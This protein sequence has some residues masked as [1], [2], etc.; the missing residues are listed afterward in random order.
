[1][2][3]IKFTC[4]GTFWGAIGDLFYIHHPDGRGS[5]LSRVDDGCNSLEPIVRDRRHAQV[6]LGGN[7][8]V[9]GDLGSGARQ[10]IEQGGLAGV[11]QPDDADL[12]AHRPLGAEADPGLSG[13]ALDVE[14][15]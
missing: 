11:R 3:E 6:R 14:N 4:L 9:R 8:R 7:R 5:D 15:V 12:E 1:M 2:S 13:V 10:R